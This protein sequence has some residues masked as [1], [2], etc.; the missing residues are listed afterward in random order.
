MIA[1]KN[2]TG[3]KESKKKLLGK[4][5]ISR[6]L[7]IAADRSNGPRERILKVAGRLFWQKSYIGTSTKD[8]AKNTGL[9]KSTI[10]YY[11]KSKSQILYEIV[12]EAINELLALAEPVVN[13]DLSSDKKLELLIINH[14]KWETT[15]PGLAGIGQVERKNLPPKLMRS[16]TDLRDDYENMF[17]KVIGEVIVNNKFPIE[18]KLATQFTLGLLNSVIYWYKPS[19]KLTDEEI[20][21]KAF[22]YI[23]RALKG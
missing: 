4:N 16:F 19:G 18:P 13:S 6:G 21:Q 17:R 9:N 7:R 14:L 8:V 5:V 22:E 10:Y 15:H 2:Q 3:I 20:A 11:F 12:F 23:T 1:K